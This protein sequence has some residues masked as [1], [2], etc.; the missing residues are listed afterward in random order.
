MTSRPGPTPGRAAA[1][2]AASPR[3]VVGPGCGGSWPLPRRARAAILG[4]C[5]RASSIRASPAGTLPGRSGRGGAARIPLTGGRRGRRGALAAAL[6]GPWSSPSCP[7]REIART[8]PTCCCAGITTGCPGR[9]WRLRAH[10]SRPRRHAGPRR[11]LDAGDGVI[12]TSA[13][14]CRS[15]ILGGNAQERR[16]AD[17]DATLRHLGAAGRR[18]ARRTITAGGTARSGT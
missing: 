9:A 18:R 15:E 13:D 4:V 5:P 10:G 17:V 11:L 6:P 8:R 2:I 1:A 16:D 14:A 3:R 12:A 7:R